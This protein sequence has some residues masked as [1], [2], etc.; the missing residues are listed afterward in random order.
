MPKH[1]I[2]KDLGFKQIIKELKKIDKEPYTKIGILSSDGKKKK[3]NAIKTTVLDVAIA[4][5]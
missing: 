2:D 5:V 1:V 4:N 3:Q